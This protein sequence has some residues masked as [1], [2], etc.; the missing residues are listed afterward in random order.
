VG[1]FPSDCVKVF[2]GKTVQSTDQQVC[3]SASSAAVTALNGDACDAA[4]ASSALT[5]EKTIKTKLSPRRNRSLVRAL[6]H[7]HAQR[8]APPVFGTDLI[9]YLRKTGDDVPIILKKCV[10]AIEMHGIVTGVYRQCGIQSNIQKL[11]PRRNRSLVRALLHRHAQR[12][13]PP[14]FGTD[15]I[16]YLRKTG[17]DGQLLR[18]L[19]YQIY[20][21][22]H[23]SPVEA[24]AVPIIL[25]KCVEAIEMH[26]IVTGVYRQCGIQSNIQKLR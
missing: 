11:S 17:D 24:F 1:I 21:E 13:A 3:S 23:K 16:E 6:L 22:L 5:N 18:L 7:R 12:Q 19:C 8:Q 20:F 25:K 9:E 14:V 4:A 2:D 26:G 10:E 15:L